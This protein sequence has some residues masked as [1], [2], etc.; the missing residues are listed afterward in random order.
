MS[1]S[2][3]NKEI[4]KF[5]MKLQSRLERLG[6]VEMIDVVNCRNIYTRHGQHL[7]TDGKENMVKKIASAIECLLSKQVG[8]ITAKWHSEKIPD[9]LDH[10]L[11]QD[12]IDNN[13]EVETKD[14]S[15]TLGGLDALKL[16]DAEQKY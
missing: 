16:Q 9:T 1:N 5:N 13:T 12:V 15:K 8:L 14:R 6:G 11:V 10:Q 7:N 2:C 3:V 4:E